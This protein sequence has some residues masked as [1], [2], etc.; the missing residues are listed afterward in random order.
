MHAQQDDLDTDKNMHG[1]VTN[2]V[3][4]GSNI[5]NLNTMKNN[6][7]HVIVNNIDSANIEQ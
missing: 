3:H 5:T 7:V 1:T 4:E 6:A 2:G